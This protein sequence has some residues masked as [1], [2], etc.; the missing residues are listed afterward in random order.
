MQLLALPCQIDLLL[1]LILVAISCWQ[2]IVLRSL[3]KHSA[4]IAPL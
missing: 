3:W 4:F 1:D 2:I